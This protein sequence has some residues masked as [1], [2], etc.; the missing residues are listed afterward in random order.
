MLTRKLIISSKSSKIIPKSIKNNLAIR[1][2]KIIMNNI[3]IKNKSKTRQQ[4]KNNNC[5]GIRLYGYDGTLKYSTKNK[6]SRK[7]LKNII[8]KIDKMPM[9]VIEKRIRNAK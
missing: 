4:K 5:M 8:N 2:V 9:G 1:N 3:K 7:I 6:I